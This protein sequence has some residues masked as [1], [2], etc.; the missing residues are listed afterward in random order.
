MIVT[1]CGSA[2]FE[3]LFKVWNEILTLS[4]HTVFSL[5]VYPS[6]KAGT[7]SW[8]TEEEK[9]ILDAAHLRKINASDAVLFLNRYGYMGE[10]TLNEVQHARDNGKLL[11]A[12]EAWR[13]G[14]GIQK[15][16][17]STYVMR[18][19]IKDKLH[20][21]PPDDTFTKY[22]GS[23]ID[24]TTFLR[25]VELLPDFSQES[26]ERLLAMQRAVSYNE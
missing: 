19:L 2:R 24:T 6:D 16:S 23:P 26:R 20:F 13:A 5:A 14:D 8:Y 9:L 15:Q 10:S 22:C 12:L 3:R 17:L 7:K 25:A 18:A 1:L 11:Y 21:N 4:G